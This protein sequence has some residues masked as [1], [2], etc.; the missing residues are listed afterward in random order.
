M[1]GLIES[2]V[3]CDHVYI[4]GN[5]VWIDFWIQSVDPLI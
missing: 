1:T 4:H 3:A 5:F 2:C